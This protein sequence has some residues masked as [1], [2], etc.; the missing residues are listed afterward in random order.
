M[1]GEPKIDNAVENERLIQSVSDFD[2]LYEVLRSI[3][4]VR[5]QVKD[6]TAERLIEKIEGVRAGTMTFID[7]TRTYGLRDKVVGLMA[8]SQHNG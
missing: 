8:S 6:Y 2:S 4:T 3:G 7:I 5:G 1:E